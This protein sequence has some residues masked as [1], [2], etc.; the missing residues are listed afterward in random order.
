MPASRFAHTGGLPPLL[1][2]AASSGRERRPATLS[3]LRPAPALVLLLA[4]AAACLLGSD[5]DRWAG[6]SN[7][8]TEN[9]MTVAE[10]LSPEH[11]FLGFYEQRLDG[12]GRRFYVP[13]NRFPVLGHLLIKLVT[14]PFPDDA[15]ARLRAARLLMLALHAAAAALAWLALRRLA[16]DPWTALAA[17]LLAFSSFHALYYADMVATEG[18]V[19]LFGLMLAFH[20]MAVF[21]TEG[22][23]GQLVAKTCGALLLGWHVYALVGPFVLLGLASAWRRGDGRAARRCLTLGVVAV[24]FGSAVLGTNVAREHAALGGETPLAELPSVQSALYRTSVVSRDEFDWPGF[25]EQQFSRIGLASVPYAVSRFVV[26]VAEPPMA[27]LYGTPSLVAVS[28]LVVLTTLVLVVRPT[29]RHRLPLMALALAGPCWAVTLRDGIS[30]IKHEFYG[31]FY[32]GVPLVLFALALDRV[33]RRGWRD[34][35]VTAITGAVVGTVAAAT[36]VLSGLLM[37]RTV[38]DPERAE[39]ERTLAADFD[40]IGQF[41]EGKTS[42]MPTIMHID[43]DRALDGRLKLGPRMRFPQDGDIR[44]VSYYYLRGVVKETEFAQESLADFVL[45]DRLPGVRSLTP[46]NRSF[47]LY[48]RSVYEAAL[49]RYERR[50]RPQRPI[51]QSPDYDVH[52]VRNERGGNALLYLRH[53]CPAAMSLRRQPRFFLHVRPVDVNDLPAAWRQHGFE[54]RDFGHVQFRRRDG[55]CYAVRFLPDYGIASI[56]TGQF[57]M[58]RTREGVRYEPVWAGSFSPGDHDGAGAVPP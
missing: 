13:Y 6:G 29:V 17:T 12:D 55:E 40:V 14:L 31:M 9:H 50:G 35:R 51:L 43:A 21:A 58:R 24:L 19:D 25:A 52:F 37:A 2:A 15:W 49:A 47:F 7:V 5:P 39:R 28:V 11:R 33:L 27:H 4:L 38:H 48:D 32:A 46:D 44:R 42:A 18:V 23:F 1:S 45:G 34:R 16:R 57:T 53:E 20:G 8:I 36:F 3:P 56:R 41:A 30:G 54:N 26:D 10:N 22:R